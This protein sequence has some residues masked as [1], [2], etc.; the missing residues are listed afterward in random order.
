MILKGKSGYERLLRE[1]YETANLI[2]SDFHRREFAHPEHI[3]RRYYT[4]ESELRKGILDMARQPSGVFHTVNRFF[5][6]HYPTVDH[7]NV[8]WDLIFDLDLSPYTKEVNEDGE[9]VTVFDVDEWK[10]RM[11]HIDY[12]RKL[13]LRLVEEFLVNLGI[14]K[15]DI[16]FE[17]SGNK[18]FH[19]TV[20][21]V[22]TQK[23]NENQRR[24][25]VQYITGNNLNKELIF[26]NGRISK[27]GWGQQGIA[28][29]M[30]ISQDQEQV[31]RY[32]KGKQAKK[33]TDAL[34]EPS[35]IER[36]QSGQLSDFNITSLVSGVVKRHK[37]LKNVIDV[38]V[39]PD[40]KRIIRIPGSIHG[41]TGLPSVRLD[42][43]QMQ[44]VNA[45]VD[46]IISIAGSDLVK[47]ELEHEC[48]IHFP[49]VK[50]FDAGVHEVPRFE[51]LCLLSK[52]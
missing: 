13:T 20:D 18:G 19:I 47:V 28:L 38:K 17:F 12:L 50:K 24:M 46:E 10:N 5:D 30:E 16:V 9:E 1:H 11:Y 3:R 39:T 42:Y 8:K 40:A 6:P 34:S 2:A 36:L 7:D 26:P 25:I 49:F 41:K 43:E 31:N 44:N 51:A 32:F 15:D 45:I 23:L 29:L 35:V 22:E 37:E 48:E 27:Y 52:N 4:S 21:N 14:S 33:I